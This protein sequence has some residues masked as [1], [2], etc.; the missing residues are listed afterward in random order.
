M[1]RIGLDGEKERIEGRMVD[2]AQRYAIAHDWRAF[3]G[4]VPIDVCRVEER[5]LLQAAHRATRTVGGEDTL[6]KC[7]LV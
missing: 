6:T 2:A 4:A 7:R 1:Q 3:W 5:A